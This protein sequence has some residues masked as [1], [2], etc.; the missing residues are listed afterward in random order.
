MHTQSP[1]HRA[2]DAAATTTEESQ[3]HALGASG[4]AG[5]FA[6]NRL[7]LAADIVAAWD[8]GQTIW[9]LN[10][11]GLG[12]G[13]DQAIQVAVIEILRD[14]LGDPLPTEQDE[15]QAWAGKTL[16]RID[17]TLGLS[18]AQWGAAKWLAFQ[19]LRTGWQDVQRRC[20]EQG[21]GEQLQQFRRD[22]P[23]VPR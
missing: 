21:K 10:L 14:H 18:G 2:V 5:F 15:R 8:A 16:A 9:S 23:A 20:E 11:G 3:P 12:P 17:A 13:Y 6:S 19:I 1:D 22:F 7:D 4:A